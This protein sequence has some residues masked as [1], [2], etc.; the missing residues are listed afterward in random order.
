ML[1]GR[2]VHEKISKSNRSHHGSSPGSH[3]LQLRREGQRPA[4]PS[5]LPA[6]RQLRQ[7][8]LVTL[9]RQRQPRTLLPVMREPVLVVYTARSEA[10]NNA[11]IPE[12]E[13]IRESRWRW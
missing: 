6:Q 8:R 13:R 9:L 2:N 3:R 11:V 7:R 1:K 12:F 10:L 5:S 4:T